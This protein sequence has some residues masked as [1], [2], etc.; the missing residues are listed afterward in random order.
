MR[1][2]VIYGS[3]WGNTKTVVQ[4]LPGLLSFS[5]NVV[6][7]KTL[8][9]ASALLSHDLL[10]FFMSTAGDQELQVDMEH[11]VI[12]QSVQ[13]HGKPY[14]ICELG[15]YYGYADFEFGAEKILRHTLQQWGG[16]EFVEPFVMDTFPHK[17]WNGLARWCNL[18]NKKV[19]E[20]DARL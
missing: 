3:T 12:R 14:G 17:D 7:V 18:L 2:L 15:N 8:A 9:D 11:F 4:R 6:D 20:Y 16:T 19:A 13:L 5:F 10:V 1:A